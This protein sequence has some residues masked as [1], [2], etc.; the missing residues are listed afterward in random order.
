MQRAL[1]DVRHD[2]ESVVA[3]ALELAVMLVL[4]QPEHV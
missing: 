1:R 3:A 4:A 2:S